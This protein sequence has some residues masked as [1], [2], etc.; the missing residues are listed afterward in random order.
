[1]RTILLFPAVFLFH[2]V[3]AQVNDK[4]TLHLALGAGAGI[5]G[6]HFEQTIKFFG[7]PIT[8]KET[9]G[10]ATITY[11]I[12]VHYGLAKVFSLGVYVE[13]GSYLDSNATRSNTLSMFGIHPRF[14]VVNNDRFAWTAGLQ[15]GSTSLTIEDSDPNGPFTNVFKGPHVALS[16]GVLFFFGDHVGL[17]VRGRFLNANFSLKEWESNGVSQSLDDYSSNLTTNGFTLS[18]SLAFRF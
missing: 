12:E 5:H 14:Y 3:T 1:M 15:F 4:G 2:L 8:T 11:P 16:T 18:A 17:Q 9:D 13:P 10:A 6:T 7:V